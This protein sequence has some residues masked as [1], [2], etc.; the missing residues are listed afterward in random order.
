MQCEKQTEFKLLFISFWI[1]FFHD[2]V[3]KSLG[4]K[5]FA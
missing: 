3:E 1:V 4:M 2:I 5:S